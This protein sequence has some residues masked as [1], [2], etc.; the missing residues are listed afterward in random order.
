MYLHAFQLG[1]IPNLQ[2]G[3]ETRLDPVYSRG[4]ERTK[5]RQVYTIRITATLSY[6][7]TKEFKYSPHPPLIPSFF[8]LISH[9]TSSLRAQ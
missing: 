5:E 3:L 9:L 4:E 7:Q 6:C 1:P 8:F 2:P